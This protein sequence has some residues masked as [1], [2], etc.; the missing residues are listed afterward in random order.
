MYVLKLG[1]LDG[2]PGLAYA[3]EKAKYFRDVGRK[4]RAPERARS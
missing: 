3:W 1:F 4:M 2:W